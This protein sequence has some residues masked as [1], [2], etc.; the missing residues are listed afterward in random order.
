[1]TPWIEPAGT[2]AA[3]VP[4]Q[5]WRTL[6]IPRPLLVHAEPVQRRKRK[7]EVWRL[8]DEQGRNRVFAKRCR[9]DEAAREAL[10]YRDVLPRIGLA[11][12]HYLGCADASD[13]RTAWLFV[14]DVVGVAYRAEEP[15]HRH[16]AASWL[17]TLHSETRRGP[18]LHGLPDVGPLRYRSML[19]DL[20]RSLPAAAG[21]P[22]LNRADVGVV[23]KAAT[24]CRD[25][26]D[27]WPSIER[28]AAALPH[29]L[30]HGSFSRRN[31]LVA[32]TADGPAL[33]AFDWGAAG[34]GVPA[35]DVAKLV[36]PTIA[37]NGVAGTA[38]TYWRGFPELAIAD[39]E[40]LIALGGLFRAIE[41]LT[42]VAARLRYP[43]VEGPL[44]KAAARTVEL[45]TADSVLRRL[46]ERRAD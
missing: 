44:R 39:R 28:A 24:C 34:W 18:A 22:E 6:S 15:M 29:S 8:S 4:L 33:R 13:G 1:M 45:T 10:V 42:W 38:E 19:D 26:V 20:I 14:R 35:R 27:L 31:M 25:L 2:A 16:L 30:V 11:A 37:G 7:A 23:D 36:G 17:S 46:V 9:L 40:F 12:E 21:N 43:C 5:A 32:P 41:H 3:G